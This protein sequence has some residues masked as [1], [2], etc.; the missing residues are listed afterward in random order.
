MAGIVAG[1]E[2]S[3][4][5]EV[6]MADVPVLVDFSAT[7]CHSCHAMEPTLEEIARE[8][9]EKLKVVKISVNDSPGV[10]TRFRVQTLPTLILFLQ[11]QP[12]DRLA[13]YLSKGRLMTRLG[14]HIQGL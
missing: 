3:F 4:D 14:D 8:Q 1:T 6:L 5:A 10:A 12:V 9:A 11:G 7:W 2:E 13:G